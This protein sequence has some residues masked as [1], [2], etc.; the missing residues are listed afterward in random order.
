MR[1]QTESDKSSNNAGASLAHGR[2]LTKD[3]HQL[4]QNL[5]DYKWRVSNLYYVKDKAGNKVLFKPNFAQKL[6]LDNM[7][8]FSIILKARQLGITTFFCIVFLDQVLWNAN[9]TAGIIAH[10]D[11]DAKKIFKDKIKFAWDNLPPDLQAQLGPPNTDSAG[12][13]S[14]PNGS[15]IFVSTSTRG[16]TIQYLH[17]SEFG[18]I[19]AH[20]PQKAEE[21]VTGSINS[22]EQ[23]Q[24]VTIESTAEGRSGYFYEFCEEAQKLEHVDRELSPME[25]R[26]FFFPWWKNPAYAMAGSPV[27]TTEFKE[28]FQML[29]A[30]HGIVLTKEQKNWY[31]AKKALNG[32][33]MY[34]E[35][36]SI[37]EEAFH[38]SIQGAYYA[39][40]MMKVHE[41]GRII[42]LPYDS[43]LPVDTWWDLG[44]NDKNVCIFTQQVGNEIRFI[45]Y[46]ENSGEGLAHYVKMLQDRGYVYGK[47]TFPH[48]INVKELGTGQS[49]YKTLLDLNLRNIRTVERTKSV[50]DDIEAVRKLFSRFYFDEEKTKKLTTALEAYRKQWNDKTGEFMNSPLH[51]QHS[52]ACDAMRTLARGIGY[53]SLG[54]V[55]EGNPNEGVVTSDFF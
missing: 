54:P 49:R 25:F 36:P 14:F 23:G 52:H 17:I 40:E 30:K 26:F 47:H 21:I 31:M 5:K 7:W 20:Y 38:A 1:Q 46:Y 2:P 11:R 12:E 51:D 55:G 18:Y 3:E 29:A 28:Y 19:C 41:T 43:A 4:Q 10:K 37:P 48:D 45:D 32:D 34:A 33:K 15:S 9:K 53:A 6:L 16:G 22:V 42:R 24:V 35:Y 13:L 39:T 8:F 44:M 27:I 50:V